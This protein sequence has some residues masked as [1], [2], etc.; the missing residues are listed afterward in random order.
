MALIDQ[1]NITNCSVAD[2]IGSGQVG[3]KFDFKNLKD[4]RFWKK[5]TV[6]ASTDTYN[7]AYLRTQQQAGNMI[8]VQDL[9]D[10]TW[11]DPTDEVETAEAT[12]LEGTT[13]KGLYGLTAMWRKGLYQQRILEALEGDDIWDVQLVDDEGNELWSET[14]SGGARGFST[15]RVSVMGIS[16]N[17]GGTSQKTSISIQFS[18]SLQFNRNLAWIA[19]ENLDY[20]RDEITGAN[21][22]SVTVPTAPSDTDTTFAAKT[23]LARGG[24]FVSGLTD[25]ANW[26]VKVNGATVT[27]TGTAVADSDAK[28]Y[29]F[30]VSALSTS[31]VVTVAL[32]DS[33][34]ASS[35]IILNPGTDDVL[36]K[37][38]TGTTTVVA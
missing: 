5:G 30:T 9:Y 24:A 26:I 17:K 3:C 25:L 32:Y 6:T 8:P 16:F 15:S 23:L 2:L 13:R 18:N 10:F 22:V 4:L 29:T 7:K 12:G 38:S 1:L 19:A 34:A 11:T 21:Q 14:S 31:D 28:T 27:P 35:T 37:S 33:V 20:F 36:Y